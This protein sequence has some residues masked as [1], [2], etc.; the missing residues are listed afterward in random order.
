MGCSQMKQRTS[1][2]LVS[3]EQR[4]DSGRKNLSNKENSLEKFV[5]LLIGAG[6]SGKSSK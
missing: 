1:D 2:T 3:S 4:P 5:I 6:D